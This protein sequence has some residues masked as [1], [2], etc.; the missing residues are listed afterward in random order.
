MKGSST[1][2]RS[3]RKAT[4]RLTENSMKRGGKSSQ[5]L[6]NKSG[7][8]QRKRKKHED[9]SNNQDSGENIEKKYHDLKWIL[10]VE[11]EESLRNSVGRYIA[12]EGQYIVTG[13]VDARSAM[14]ICRGII[15]PNFEGR[16]KQSFLGPIDRVTSTNNDLEDSDSTSTKTI[17]KTP[18]CLILD[19]RLPGPMNGLELL[20][21]IR[22]DTILSSLPVVLLT[23]R[24]RVEDR[25]AGYDAGADAY[26]SKPFDPEELLSIIDSLLKRD[27]PYIP[28]SQK[29]DAVEFGDLMNELEEIEVL[30]KKLGFTKKRKN[31]DNTKTSSNAD[32]SGISIEHLRREFSEIKE[33]LEEKIDQSNYAALTAQELLSNSSDDSGKY[34]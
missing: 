15:R 33:M 14:L 19:I 25:I 3:E 21:T 18:D 7:L 16:I 6:S 34:K 11:D 30:L 2:Q 23:A 5:K 24:G 26:L 1:Q 22:D 20:K 29:D 27:R 31:V 12:K 4:Q 8:N 13:V 17:P 10:L 32:D 28:E 9:N